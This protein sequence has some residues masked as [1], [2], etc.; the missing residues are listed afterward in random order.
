MKR[1]TLL[2]GTGL[3]ITGIAAMGG[4][5]G[6]AFAA[7][8][9]T[10]KPD[11]APLDNELEKYPRCV[12]CNMDR[13]KFHFSRHLLHYADEHAEGT[14]SINCTSEVMLRERKRGFKAIYAAD[15]G[16]VAEPK[17]LVEASAATYLIGS[18]LRAVMSPVS[19]YAF[20]QRSAAEA[21][22]SDAGGQLASFE[23]AVAASLQDYAKMV[24]QKYAQDRQS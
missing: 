10:S 21:A 12:I 15:F 5:T 7:G 23:Q 6:Q 24:T 8:A 3:A 19:K 11:A 9:P 4:L 2:K 22:M 20:A 17:P 1:R 13:S 16:V 14:C 18:S